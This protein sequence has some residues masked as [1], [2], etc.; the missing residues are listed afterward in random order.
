MSDSVVE[1]LPTI[2]EVERELSKNAR[3]ARML[4]SLRDMLRR[5]QDRERA[6]ARLRQVKAAEDRQEVADAK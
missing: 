5:K 1:K 2:E 6:A 3:D 4:R